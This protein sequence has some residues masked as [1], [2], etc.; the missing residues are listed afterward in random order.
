MYHANGAQNVWFKKSYSVTVAPWC[1]LIC[2]PAHV[3]T[4]NICISSLWTNN[5]ISTNEHHLFK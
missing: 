2:L 4:E 3:D 5:Y 1:P